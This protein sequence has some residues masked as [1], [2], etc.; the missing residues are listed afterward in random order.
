MTDKKPASPEKHL[1][2][3]TLGFMDYVMPVTE[4]TKILQALERAERYQYRHR[5]EED[6]GPLHHIWSE[7][8]RV[9]MQMIG[10]STYLQGKFTGKPDD[11]V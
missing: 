10:Y 8:P 2:K 3:I 9:G 4:A 5:S 1:A 6:G 11:I 7:P